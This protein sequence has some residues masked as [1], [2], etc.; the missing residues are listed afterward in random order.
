M[1][2]CASPIATKDRVQ[3][4]VDF[5]Q[6]P[7]VDLN[8]VD[9]NGNSPLLL[10][11]RMNHCE[12]LQSCIQA[13]LS[14]NPS[15]CHLSRKKLNINHRNH[16]G[17]NALL[18]LCR[19][20]T[21]ENLIEILY[22]LID[23]GI[24]VRATSNDGW[25]ALLLL[26]RHYK[27]ENLLHIVQL[28]IDDGKLDINQRTNFGTNSLALLCRYYT[29]GNL[30][31]IIRYLIDRGIDINCK[32]QDRRTPL[33]ILCRFRGS[34][35]VID[36]VQLLIKKGADVNCSDYDGWNPLLFL[37]NNYTRDNLKRIV[38]KFLTL[39]SSIDI[40]WKTKN[41]ITALEALSRNW[42]GMFHSLLDELSYGVRY[43]SQSMGRIILNVSLLGCLSSVRHLI[44]YRL[45]AVPVDVDTN[46]QITPFDHLEQLTK[47]SFSLCKQCTPFSLQDVQ[48]LRKMFKFT[49]TIEIKR[50]V[51]RKD[52]EFQNKINYNDY[53]TY[54]HEGRARHIPV[55][56]LEEWLTI[57]N[58][59]HTKTTAPLYKMVQN[60]L[61]KNS[62]PLLSNHSDCNWCRVAQDVDDYLQPLFNRIKILDPLFETK[63]LIGY[64]SST[65]KTGVFL[66]SESDRAVV[67]VHFRQS[68]TNAKQVFYAGTCPKASSTLMENEPINS[69]SL[70]RYFYKLVNAVKDCAK[71][72]HVFGPI[73]G[74]SETCVTIHFLYRGLHPPAI[75]A[76]VDITLAIEM[77]QPVMQID[78][79]E[80]CAI[81]YPLPSFLV[82]WRRSEGSHWQVTYFTVERDLLS[83]AGDCVAKVHKL[84]KFLLV[85]HEENNNQKKDIPRKFCPSS[86]A[87]KTCVIQYLIRCSP[88]PWHSRDIVRH[89]IG[90]LR[91][92]P[93][94]S[95]ELK[96]FFD[97][98][99]VVYEVS[100]KSKRSVLE[101]IDKLEH[102]EET[103]PDS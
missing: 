45:F 18:L 44:M 41:G 47:T 97:P 53:S 81:P 62:H 36:I 71:S 86:Y 68:P 3:K 12:D 84:L 69:S 38:E 21:D 82:P 19:Y 57:S 66:P 20:H 99:L 65:E 101:V 88:P 8:C 64:G 60:Y 74:Y 72:V 46:C 26:S 48:E 93:T 6:D 33:G 42:S 39:N 50:T 94:D 1:V 5:V 90:V 29:R 76:S 15:I 24:D 23:F 31:E 100:Q 49:Q 54:R 73:V 96:S 2:L 7:D 67:L 92:Y 32:N 52:K 75:K 35:N 34:E 83:L 28:L 25:N 58:L 56:F 77:E 61:E 27:N 9:R 89:A 4:I 87:L 37:L 59:W 78:L 16:Q 63:P 79:P 30:V 55:P 17:W 102:F 70:L 11:C 22:L 43:D 80:W 14:P 103:L 40:G 98:D 51:W 85:L 91:Q 10:L 13:I 95:S